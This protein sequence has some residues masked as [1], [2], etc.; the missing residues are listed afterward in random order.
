MPNKRSFSVANVQNVD[1]CPTKFKPGRYL[2]TNPVGSAKKA[3][4]GLCNVKNIKGKCT[5]VVT[6]RE[7]SSGS[8]KKEFTYKC[9]RIKLKEPVVIMAGTPNEFRRMYDIKAISSEPIKNCKSGRVRTRGPMRK[10]HTK[11]RNK[12]LSGRGEN[13][14]SGN[15]VSMKKT[16]KGKG[17]NNRSM[18]RNKS[19]KKNRKTPGVAGVPDSSW[20][21]TT[22]KK[23]TDKCTC[24]PPYNSENNY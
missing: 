1:G 3:F 9:E 16:E 13:K 11:R 22:C 18:K 2:S 4:N 20:K 17:S 7:T 15:N 6:M 24:P 19:S 10:K 14:K 23:K 8:P 5:L 21:C 12:Y